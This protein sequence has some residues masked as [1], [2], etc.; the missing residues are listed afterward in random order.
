MKIAA[1]TEPPRLPHAADHDDDEGAQDPVEPHRVIDADER[2]EQ[3]AARPGIADPIA[4]TP[5]NTQGTGIPIACAMMRSCVVARIQMPQVPN[6]RNSQKPPMIAAVQPGDH[7]PVQG[8][9]PED[10]Y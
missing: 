3:H 8:V 1:S 5:A 9:I 7:Q 4:N 10:G 2:A 6:F